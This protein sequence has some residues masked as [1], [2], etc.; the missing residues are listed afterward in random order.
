MEVQA[1]VVAVAAILLLSGCLG[2]TSPGTLST[3]SDDPDNHWRD[4]VVTVSYET[5]EGTTRE[6]EPLVREALDYW[7]AHS[8]EYAG[9]DVALRL[10][11]DGEQADIH[12]S[13]VDSVVDCGAHSG[14]GT[15]GCAPVLTDSQA[16]DRPADVQV[17]AGLSNESTIRI[18]EHELGHTLGLE[19]GDAP[20]DVMQSTTRVTTV[21]QRNA[22][23][24][25]LPWQSSALSVHVDLDDAP[26][27]ERER[28]RRQVN[29][30]LQYY[31]AGAD[32]TVPENVTFD[33]TGS[34]SD[35]DVVIDFESTADCHSG[36]G[37]CGTVQ[38]TDPDG[39]GAVEYHDT[40]TVV[41][42]GLD[43]DAVGWH[44]AR[45]LGT[46]FGHTTESAYPDPL[47]QPTTREERRGYWWA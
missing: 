41:L 37:S 22:T 9:Y 45:W 32:G 31:A 47:R 17:R 33:R 24:R 34:R 44:V 23:N 2:A 14:S 36:A 13:F 18:L 8:A 29:A 15:A 38:G 21:P 28:M 40:L 43:A 35:A 10:A 4:D 25:S 5:P 20:G 12:V 19:H 26:A 30:A 46:G 27:G 11:D 42:V 16:V 39:D 7:T 3:W 6:Y 1:R